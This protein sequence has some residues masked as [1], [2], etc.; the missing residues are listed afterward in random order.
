MFDKI[1]R[2]KYQVILST[3]IVIGVLGFDY[4]FFMKEIPLGNKDM[5]NAAFGALNLGMG[6]IINFWLGASHKA[7][8]DKT[9]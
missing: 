5:A 7:Q 9:A 2:L 1:N 6:T 4:L 8:S 3:I